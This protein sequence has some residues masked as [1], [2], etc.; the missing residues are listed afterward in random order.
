MK[1]LFKFITAYDKYAIKAFE[2]S[3]FDY[4]LKPFD[5][6]RFYKVLKRAKNNHELI[7]KNNHQ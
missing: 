7:N 5:D 1:F 3:A 4:L 2:A 6:E